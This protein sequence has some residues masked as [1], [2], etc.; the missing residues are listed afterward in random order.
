M[1]Q[2]VAEPSCSARGF[3]EPGGRVRMVTRNVSLVA[4]GQT[5]LAPTANHPS[6]LDLLVLALVTD[7]LAALHRAASRAGVKV[8]DAELSVSASLDSPLVALGVVGESGSPALASVRGALYVQC[9]A[10]AAGLEEL[11]RGA[12]ERSPVHATL[13]RCADVRLDLKP[14]P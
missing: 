4:E 12:L 2:D 8:F 1:M 6:A 13:A 5:S 3:L 11:W 7:V 9:D 10:S 14:V